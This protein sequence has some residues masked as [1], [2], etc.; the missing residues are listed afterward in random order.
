MTS[1][2]HD[3][4]VEITSLLDSQS[5]T[6][7]SES[8][9]ST[10][11][12]DASPLYPPETNTQ[13]YFIILWQE[14]CADVTSQKS[15]ASWGPVEPKRQKGSTLLYPSNRSFSKQN[16]TKVNAKVNV[17]KWVNSRNKQ[18]SKLL[19]KY[20]KYLFCISFLLNDFRYFFS[21]G[22]CWTGKTRHFT[23]FFN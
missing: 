18:R 6:S 19:L 10:V 5:I 11:S 23:I 3:I 1:S 20:V 7:D 2:V 8:K 14:L 22:H 13:D 4:T 16:K 12:A 9:S 15:S 17:I 21:H